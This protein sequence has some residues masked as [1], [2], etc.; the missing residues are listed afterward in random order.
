MKKALFIVIAII[1]VGFLVGN[2]DTLSQ[3][4]TTA[5]RGATLPLVLSIIIMLLRHITQAVSYQAAFEAVDF[6]GRKLWDYVVL[7]FS[8]VFINTFCL[9]S[10]A[11]GVAFIIDDAHR[12]G[13]DIGKA[14]SGAVLSQIG[15]FAAVLVIS[16]IGFTTMIVSGNVNW[17][18]VTG[19][20]LLAGTLIALSSMYLI[21]FFRPS[22]LYSF[23]AKLYVPLGS[24]AQKVKRPLRESWP[25]DTAESF[26]TAAR[27]MAANPSGTAVSVAWASFSAILNMSSLVAIGYAFGFNNVAALVAAFALAAISVIL[28]P[29]PQGIGVVEAAIAAVLTAYGCSLAT[30][31]AIALVYRGIMFWIPFCI[32]AVLLSQS[33]FFQ[34]KKDPTQEQKDKDTAWITG[35]LVGIIGIVNIGVT[36]VPAFFRPY[37]QLVE[38]VDFHALFAGPSIFLFGLLLLV[39]AIGL[40]RRYRLAWAMTATMLVLL[41]GVEFL[42][43]QTVPV[44]IMSLAIAAWLM[45]HSSTFDQPLIAVDTKTGRRILEF[46]QGEQATQAA[47]AASISAG[48]IPEPEEESSAQAA[49]SIMDGRA[50]RLSAAEIA[51]K[52]E[53][54][55]S[56]KSGGSAQRASS[57][58]ASSG[59]DAQGANTRANATQDVADMLAQSSTDEDGVSE[60]LKEAAEVF[61]ASGLLDEEGEGASAEADEGMAAAESTAVSAEEPSDESAEEPSEVVS[62][63]ESVAVPTEADGG[64]SAEEPSDESVEELSNEPA[65]EKPAEGSSSEPAK[66]ID[67]I[68]E[69]LPKD[70]AASITA[71]EPVIS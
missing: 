40:V 53:E 44:A 21:G 48:I 31:T 51:Y 39:M 14:T 7:I 46:L 68:D 2:A 45:V 26:I 15:Y 1:A 63:A 57:D 6:K 70:D 9:F 59:E 55:E 47:R 34:S 11:T 66:P 19:A 65:E 29:T 71:N 24:V 16:I 36:I 22:W 56:A 32:G 23:F 37:G 5:Q 8:L 62:A 58:Q 4:F 60:R 69:V 12:N 27:V 33:G 25:N 67:A 42:F 54:M 18:F 61:A 41:A 35:T 38:W 30:A 52:I 17:L 50:E 13:A 3:I 10:G 49:F 28:S 43:Y 20:V 64:V